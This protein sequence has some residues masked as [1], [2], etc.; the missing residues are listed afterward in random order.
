MRLNTLILVTYL[1]I[2]ALTQTNNPA[3]QQAWT[4]TSPQPVAQSQT[5]TSPLP[6]IS[7]AIEAKVKS[8]L[9]VMI[10]SFD[11][12]QAIDKIMKMVYFIAMFVIMF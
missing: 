3:P 1:A 12:N 2:P 6:E 8:D 5:P 7:K 9:S 11:F 10:S 4:A